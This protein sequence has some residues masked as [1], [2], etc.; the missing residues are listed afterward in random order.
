MVLSSKIND[1]V[2]SDH[3]IVSFTLSP[4]ENVISNRTW[5]MNRKY[6]LDMDFMRCINSN[7]DLFIETNV[8][9]ADPQD[10]PDI[11]VI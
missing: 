1:I 6:L 8:T 2:I 3:A 4:K 10:K 11:G 5:R 7:I 9:R